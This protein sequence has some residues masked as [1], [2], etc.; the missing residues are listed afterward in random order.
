MNDFDRFATLPIGRPWPA[1]ERRARARLAAPVTQR[2]VGRPRAARVCAWWRARYQW[3]RRRRAREQL[4][5]DG[6]PTARRR[7]RAAVRFHTRCA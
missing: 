6:Q 3:R 1:T 4:S 2:R 5:Y 7:R